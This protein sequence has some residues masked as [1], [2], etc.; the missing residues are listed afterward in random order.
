MRNQELV[1]ALLTEAIRGQGR[2]RKRRASS[3]AR[4]KPVAR[5]RKVVHRAGSKVSRRPV[6]KTVRRGKAKSPYIA[7]VKSYHRQ[8]PNLTWAQAM[9]KA[10]PHYHK[11]QG[12]SLRSAASTAMRYGSKINKGLRDSKLISKALRGYSTLPLPG[13][14]AANDLSLLA[15]SLGYGY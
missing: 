12:G 14:T 2:P 10:S 5:R 4:S 15:S 7:F 9:R 1:H 3:K 13:S 8:H 11:M 6:R